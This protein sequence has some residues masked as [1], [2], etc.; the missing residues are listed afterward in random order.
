MR[1]RAAQLFRSRVIA[2][3]LA[4]NAAELAAKGL[5]DGSSLIAFAETGEG[6]MEAEGEVTTDFNNVTRFKIEATG[7]TRGV[8]RVESG[9]GA[10]VAAGCAREADDAAQGVVQALLDRRRGRQRRQ[11]LGKDAADLHGI[12]DAAAR[13]PAGSPCARRP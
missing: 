4:E 2:Q 8:L 7:T 6:S 1:Y 9:G 12:T 10:T 5:S 3:T 13:A 11:Q